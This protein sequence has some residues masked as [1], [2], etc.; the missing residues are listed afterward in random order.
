MAFQYNRFLEYRTERD[1]I[2]K[3]SSLT[4]WRK[5]NGAW[6]TGKIDFVPYGMK[7]KS[8]KLFNNS[9]KPD[10]EHLNYDEAVCESE[11]DESVVN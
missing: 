8:K 11:L 6:G 2:I 7:K 4:E 3:T 5:K 10:T 9:E 1:G